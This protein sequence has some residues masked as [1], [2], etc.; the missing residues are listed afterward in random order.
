MFYSIGTYLGFMLTHFERDAVDDPDNMETLQKICKI[1][2]AYKNFSNPEFGS[3]K[4]DFQEG[5]E[6][7]AAEI[8]KMEADRLEDAMSGKSGIVTTRKNDGPNPC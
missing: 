2:E 1:S 8:R 3:F 4:K 6:K 7:G 5:Y